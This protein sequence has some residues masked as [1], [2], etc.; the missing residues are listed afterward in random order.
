VTDH[1]DVA[2]IGGG[3]V[4]LAQAWMAVRRRL[5]VVLL[6]R[7]ALAEGASVRNFGMIWPIGQPAGELY[8]LALRS[9]ELWR[10]L[11]SLGVVSA[12][13]CGSIHVAHRQDELAVQEEFCRL[14]THNVHMLTAEEVGR[15]LPLVNTDGLL[16]GMFSPVELRAHRV[17]PHRCLAHGSSRR[18]ML[19]SDNG[20]RR[21]GASGLRIRWASLAGRSHHCLQRQRPANALPRDTRRSGAQVVQTANAPIRRPA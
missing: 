18:R 2:V 5:R 15:R 13:E 9:R 8:A 3:I 20:R 10:V 19:F 6:E 1:F 16:G 14:G 11:H 7:S 17:R 12:E 4:G 21:R